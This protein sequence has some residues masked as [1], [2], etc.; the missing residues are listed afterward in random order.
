MMLICH[1][2]HQHNWPAKPV[3][4]RVLAVVLKAYFASTCL[5]SPR[6]PITKH[7]HAVKGMR[8]FGMHLW[9][10]YAHLQAACSQARDLAPTDPTDSDLRCLRHPH[11][12]VELVLLLDPIAEVGLPTTTICGAT[13]EV[14]DVGVGARL[15]ALNTRRGPL[16]I[17]TS[18]GTF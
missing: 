14:V 13:D 4:H 2:C 3:G 16:N 1:G 10:A 17:P 9:L 8:L 7:P 12:L 5:L 6:Q 18:S 11:S 15:F